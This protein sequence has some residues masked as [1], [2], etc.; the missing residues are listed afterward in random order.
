MQ[1]ATTNGSHHFAIRKNDDV[2]HAGGDVDHG[3]TVYGNV[4]QGMQYGDT[5]ELIVD[6]KRHLAASKVEA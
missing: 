3:I 5:V 6:G 4:C 1:T 2:I